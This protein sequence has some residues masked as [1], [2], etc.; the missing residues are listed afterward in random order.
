MLVGYTHDDIDASFGRWS[1]KLCENDYPT[2]PL[3]MKSY[4][5]LDDILVIPSLIEEVLDFKSFVKPYVSE[6]TL[7][8]HTKGRQFLFYRGDNSNPL[9]RYKLRCMDENWQPVEGI[10]L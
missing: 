5:E 2:I 3:L 6:D 7:I 10:Q 8:G 4:M 1:M 9:M